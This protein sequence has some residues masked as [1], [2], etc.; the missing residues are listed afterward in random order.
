MWIVRLALRRPLS[1]AV[2]ALLMLVLGALSFDA[3]ERRHLSRDQ[4]AGRDGGL[5]LSGPVGD[6]H[7]TADGDHQRARLLDHRQRHRA[8]RVGIDQ[9]ARHPEG[10]FPAGQ[11]HRRGDRADQRGLGNHSDDLAARHRAAANHLLQRDQRSGR[12]AEHLQR[13]ALRPAAVRL[14]AQLHSHAALHDSRLF[15]ARAARRRAALGHGQS[16]SDCAVRQRAVRRPTS[17]TRWPRP[18]WLS[19]RAPPRW[20]TTNTTSIST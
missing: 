10:V 13:H 2:M 3:D 20:A 1:V 14:R 17:A 7:R 5:E 6:R 8:Y 11:R 15:V 18:T 12:A 4:S 16:Q 19:R 9:R